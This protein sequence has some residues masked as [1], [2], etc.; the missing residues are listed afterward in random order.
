MESLKYDSG[1][2]RARYSQ[3]SEAELR[4]TCVFLVTTQICGMGDYGHPTQ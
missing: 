4:I 3:W 2:I 1:A